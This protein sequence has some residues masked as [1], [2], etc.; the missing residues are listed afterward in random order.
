MR[1]LQ[2]VYA[3]VALGVFI[4]CNKDD[5]NS[6]K[7]F[8]SGNKINYE[9][10]E[11]GQI[12]KY[13]F[14]IGEEYLNLTR[15]NYIYYTDTLVQEIISQDENGFLVQEV[16]TPGSASLNNASNVA[17]PDAVFHYYLNVNED[18][19]NN[20]LELVTKDA[21]LKTRLFQLSSQTTSSLPMKEL[22]EKEVEIIAWSTSEPNIDGILEAYVLNYENFNFTFP[23]LNVYFDNRDIK[24][25]APGTVNIY[26]KRYGLVRALQYNSSSGKGYGWDLLP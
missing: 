5:S 22:E 18:S 24:F 6:T 17:F 26:S 20:N 15:C 3:F 23:R 4:S 19:E 16:L 9:N 8:G 7:S 2:I 12:S 13:V 25:G 1:L 11:V 10:L 21:R 14:F